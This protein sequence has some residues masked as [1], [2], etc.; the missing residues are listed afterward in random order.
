MSLPSAQ[1]RTLH[2]IERALQASEPRLA[3]KF[4]IFTRLVTPDGPI[5]L[6]RINA[7]GLKIRPKIRLRLR[8]GAGFRVVALMAV[9][10]GLLITGIVVGGTAHSSD[11]CLR[12]WHSLPAR[13]PAGCGLVMQ[14]ARST[15]TP[16]LHPS[17]GMRNTPD[18]G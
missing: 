10:I 15:V 11:G 9:A 4:A 14:P 13:G 16:S 1:Q 7:P 5:G 17:R 2:Q 18:P 12:G 3:S 6:E 8:L